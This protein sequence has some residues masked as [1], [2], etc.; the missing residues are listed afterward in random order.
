MIKPKD[1]LRLYILWSLERGPKCGYDIKKEIESFAES[2]L[3]SNAILYFALRELQRNK[4]ITGTSGSRNKTIYT[5]SEKG[6]DELMS[7][8]REAGRVALH[9]KELF[10]EVLSMAEGDDYASA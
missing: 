1:L 3:V 4:Y 9:F 6:K 2:T 10:F 7:K 5:L 8:K